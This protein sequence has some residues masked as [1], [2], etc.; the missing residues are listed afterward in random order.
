MP[1]KQESTGLMGLLGSLRRNAKP[2]APAPAPERRKSRSR[3][4]DDTRYAT[5]T[6]RDETRRRR[7]D[8]KRRSMRPDIDGEEGAPEPAVVG[9]FPDA[10]AEDVEARKAARRAKRASRQA[11]QAAAD[12]LRETELREAEER[13]ARRREEKARQREE[14]ARE[15][16][17]HEKQ[18]REE[19][20]RRREEKRARRTAREERIRREEQEAREAEARLAAERRERR[21]QREA[22]MHENPGYEQ[23]QRRHRSRVDD[24]G[25]RDFYLDSHD[26]ERTRFTQRSRDDEKSSRRKSKAPPDTT[27]PTPMP[28]GARKDKTSSWVDSQADEPPEPPPIVPTVLDMPPGP[29]DEIP[30]HTMSS[31]EEARRELRRQSRRR[32]KYPGLDDQEIGDLRARKREDRRAEREN[33]KTSSSGDYERDRGM[34]YNRYGAEPPKRPGWLKKLTTFG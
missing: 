34:K 22:E 8:R 20:E 19:E 14:K 18:L 3:R 29:E 11:P 21:R 10:E 26:P 17:E 16:E 2:E 27:R 32:S 13:R 25:A 31:D 30:G 4:D 15:R 1:K 9:A 24:R 6:E 28:F 23:R 5:E 7:D 12:E 33:G